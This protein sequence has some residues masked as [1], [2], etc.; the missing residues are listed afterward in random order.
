MNSQVVLRGRP[1]E[2]SEAITGNVT[3]RS[4]KEKESNN[5][6]GRDS[7]SERGRAEMG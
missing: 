4:R 5:E 1:T 7:R 2:L 6:L 3:P